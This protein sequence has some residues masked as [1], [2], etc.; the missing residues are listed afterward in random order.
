MIV[1]IDGPAG[2]GKTSVTKEVARRLGLA[3][4]DTGA[5]Y[6]AV[7]YRGLQMGFDIESMTNLDEQPELA[8]V[9]EKLIEVAQNEPIEFDFDSAGIPTK[10]SIGGQDVTTQIRTKEVDSTVSVVSACGK[11][12]EALVDQQRQMAAKVD[13]VLEGRDIGTVVFPNA[14]IKIYLTASPEER[15]HRRVLQNIERGFGDT[16]EAATLELIKYRDQ[17]DS[18]RAN[19]PLTKAD[20]AIEIDTT[21]MTFEEVVKK[22]IGLIEEKRA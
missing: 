9:R 14:E 8:D 10:V 3:M 1:A 6:R 12:R 16:D 20:D 5:M 18:G 21:D 7:T 2:S 17:Y 11:I 15:A 19:A 22:I 13:T 4:L